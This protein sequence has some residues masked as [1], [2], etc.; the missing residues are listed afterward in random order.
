LK[1]SKRENIPKKSNPKFL[2]SRINFE[3]E[4]RTKNFKRSRKEFS[5]LKKHNIYLSFRKN[6]KKNLKSKENLY[7]V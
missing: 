5:L 2:K 7:P 4:K 6:T 3:N 1:S